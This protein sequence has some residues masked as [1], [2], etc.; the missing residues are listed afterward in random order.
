MPRKPRK[1]APLKPVLVPQPIDQALHSPLLNIEAAA[2]YLNTTVWSIRNLV[3]GGRVPF[4][5]L[6]KRYLFIK[7]DL[8]QFIEKERKVN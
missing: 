8:D 4:L 3:W 1:S 7:K 6:G 2:A 5:K